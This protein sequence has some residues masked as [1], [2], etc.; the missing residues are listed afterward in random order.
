M[1]L[2]P[3]VTFIT[4]PQLTSAPLNQAYSYQLAA[5]GFN[6]ISCALLGSVG[7]NVWAVS[8]SGLVTGTPFA[9]ENDTLTVQATDG[10]GHTAIA[11]FNISVWTFNWPNPLPAGLV[12]TPYNFTLTVLGGIAPITYG[13]APGFNLPVGLS[14][15]S[16]TGLISGT[17]TTP[18]NAQAEN[19]TATDSS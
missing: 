18:V 16:A 3:V 2:D 14:L 7:A 12:G 8:A 1:S 6:A 5:V 11:T 17:P 4:Q 9:I 19:F 13:L 15:N 10:R